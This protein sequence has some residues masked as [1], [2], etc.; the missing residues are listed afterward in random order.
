MALVGSGDLQ[1]ALTSART[2]VE[3]RSKAEK[4][5]NIRMLITLAASWRSTVDMVR[6][7]SSGDKI[8]AA[9]RRPVQRSSCHKSVANS[10]RGKGREIAGA[11]I[12]GIT[13]AG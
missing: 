9:G 8:V 13:K 1:S 12:K 5:I 6:Q 10:P 2:A 11:A 4:A 3:D 7:K